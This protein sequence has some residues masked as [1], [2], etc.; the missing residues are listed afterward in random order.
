MS[1]A[2]QVAESGQQLAGSVVVVP[3]AKKDSLHDSIGPTRGA[4]SSSDG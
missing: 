1:A 2:A 4:G 3:I